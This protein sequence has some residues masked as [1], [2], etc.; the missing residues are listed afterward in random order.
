MSQRKAVDK[1]YIRLASVPTRS[2]TSPDDAVT[3]ILSSA[4]K[5]K[6]V[7]VLRG[8]PGSGKSTVSRKLVAHGASVCS[9]D[10]FFETESGYQWEASRLAESH[11]WCQE[12]F[13]EALKSGTQMVV[14]DNTNVTRKEYEFYEDSAKE[15]G[16][17]LHILEMYCRDMLQCIEFAKRNTHNVCLGCP[18]IQLTLALGTRGDM[19]NEI[20]S[21]ATRQPRCID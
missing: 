13:T 4:A 15:A 1:F 2:T 12:Q 17:K 14:V 10:K 3:A 7:V 19:S 11:K 8:L 18:F 20:W 6:S 9:A 5:C 16:Y 21:M